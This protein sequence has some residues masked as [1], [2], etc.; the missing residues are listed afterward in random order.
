MFSKVWFFKLH[1]SYNPKVGFEKKTRTLQINCEKKGI[2]Y[3]R[4]KNGNDCQDCR[5]FSDRG[6]HWKKLISSEID[7]INNSARQLKTERI[8]F[9][10]K[11]DII[12][13]CMDKKKRY[14]LKKS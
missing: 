14:V 7:Q 8:D 1:L 11:S 5:Y 13:L 9:Y 3:S 4:N 10:M 12:F 6:L 2:T